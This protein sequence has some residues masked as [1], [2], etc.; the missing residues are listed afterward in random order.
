[1]RR[2][3]GEAVVTLGDGDGFWEAVERLL[4]RGSADGVLAHGLGPLAAHGL[5]R[6]GLPV[7]ACLEAEEQLAL[8]RMLAVEPLLKLVRAQ[9]G[10]PIVLMKGPEV[11]LRY[12]GAARGFGDL[13][14]LVPDART[15]HMQM[16]EGGFVEFGDPDSP[17]PLHHLRPL[18]WP[19]LPLR[20][21]IHAAVHWPD[22]LPAPNASEVIEH[23]L[24]SALGVEGVRAPDPA[25]HALLL[26]GH[27]WAHEPLRR[28]RDLV[29]VRAIAAEADVAELERIARS[30]EL[31]RLWK[32][33]T[34]AASSALDGRNGSVALRFW[35]GHLRGVR[36]RT[37]LE[38]HLRDALAGY[39][40]LPAGAAFGATAAALS[41]DLRRMPEETWGAKLRRSAQ[42]VRDAFLPRSHHDLLLDGGSNGGLRRTPSGPQKGSEHGQP[43]ESR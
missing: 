17:P 37:V 2:S 10:G 14:L 12:P 15:V 1:M 33:T 6:R 40:A 29:D 34:T 13:D 4:R 20:V 9:C 25:R 30:W 19:G 22:Q 28:L 5:R 38:S 18:R 23:S 36:E 39:W 7:P 26:A 35:A 11:A 31:T 42:A 41:S 8:L 16:R 27:A 43:V 3:R 21:E 24:P 32:A